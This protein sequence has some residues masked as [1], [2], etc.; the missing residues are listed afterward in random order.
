MLDYLSDEHVSLLLCHMCLL[1]NAN[2]VVYLRLTVN[3]VIEKDGCSRLQ[4]QL[5][6]K[7]ITIIC[8]GS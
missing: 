6:I 7:S 8:L 5:D 1:W 3:S 4:K 2:S